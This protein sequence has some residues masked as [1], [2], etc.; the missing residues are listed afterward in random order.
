MKRLRL[1]FQGDTDKCRIRVPGCNSDRLYVVEIINAG[2]SAGL[3]QLNLAVMMMQRTKEIMMAHW[4]QMTLWI[5][6][7][8]S[9]ND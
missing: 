3:A 9:R 6:S 8:S 1:T 7:Q 5:W 4:P 2:D